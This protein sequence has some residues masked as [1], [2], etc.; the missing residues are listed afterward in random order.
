MIA[1]YGGAQSEYDRTQ[2]SARME[3]YLDRLQFC[4]GETFPTIYPTPR[5]NWFPIV[6]HEL[7][8]F[9]TCFTMKVPIYDLC[10]VYTEMTI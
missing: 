6:T 7:F 5:E 1:G 9:F 10:F 8:D 4:Y 2:L 3:E